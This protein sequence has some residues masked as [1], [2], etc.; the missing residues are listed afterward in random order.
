M[1]GAGESTPP[2]R[3]GRI[4]STGSGQA[5]DRFGMTG[6]DSSM[7]SFD[8]S[9]GRFNYRVAA[10]VVHDGHV[11]VCRE[12]DGDF[13]FLPGGRCEMMESSHDAVR[14]ELREELGVDSNIER[15]LWI[16]ENFFIFGERRFHEFGLYFLVTLPGDS[17]QLDKSQIYAFRE[18]V[19]L[20]LEMRW[21]RLPELSAINLVP[22]FLRDGL[23][24]LP[25][26]PRH[27]IYDQI[28]R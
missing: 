26:T 14:R 12:A 8:M 17:P 10:V 16:V 19:D 27:I 20:D 15:L 21:Y 13:W 24:E 6:G 7:I 18:G 1:K 9:D 5:L 4:P 3:P 11:L 23:G 28:G 22:A 2:L 25:D